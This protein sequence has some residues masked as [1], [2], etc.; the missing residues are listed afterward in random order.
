[1]LKT[2]KK[3]LPPWY[4]VALVGIA[5]C[6]VLVITVFGLISNNRNEA[7]PEPTA[8]QPSPTLTEVAPPTPTVPEQRNEAESVATVDR[9]EGSNLVAERV[10]EDSETV[11]EEQPQEPQPNGEPDTP[12][13]EQ[14]AAPNP[15]EPE[16]TVDVV[17][18][19]GQAEVD[20][21]IGAINYWT[22][23]SYVI[24]E[25]NYCGGDRYHQ[26]EVGDTVRLTGQYNGVYRVVKIYDSY[27]GSFEYDW[28]ALHLQTSLG[29]GA[30]R[31]WQI[32]K[33]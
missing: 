8:P 27:A 4:R 29:G 10:V 24:S 9:V 13:A 25:H 1:M 11:Q 18:G 2:F 22:G 12:V 23:E 20:A 3:A 15:D 14:P 7:P 21:C 19:G 33:I 6:S 16:L 32:K 30:V 5:V 17:S 28:Q 31:L 26:L